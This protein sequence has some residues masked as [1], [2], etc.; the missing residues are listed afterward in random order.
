MAAKRKTAKTAR[1]A[2]SRKG[3]QVDWY[4]TRKG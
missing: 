3:K 4:Y 2:K 1:A